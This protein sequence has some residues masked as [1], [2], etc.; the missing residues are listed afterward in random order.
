M[1]PESRHRAYD[2]LRSELRRVG[3][4]ERHRRLAI[5]PPGEDVIDALTAAAVRDAVRALPPEQRQVVEM[6]YFGGLSYREVARAVGI[7]EGT[8]KSRIRL[9]LGK[10]ENL[11]DRQLLESS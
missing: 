3:R 6:A 2:V 9:A 1:P 11:L 7:S 8:A 4:E 10:L 5:E